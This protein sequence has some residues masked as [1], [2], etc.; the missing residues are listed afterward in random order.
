M[1]FVEYTTQF[2]RD[3][4]RIK[5]RGKNF[6]SIQKIMNLIKEEKALPYQLKD[7][8]LSGNWNHHKELHIEPDWLLIYKT[9][10][11]RKAVIFVRTGSHSD[12]FK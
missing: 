2:K 10:I 11:N 5:K 7:H 3:L 6:V 4:N 8:H 12:L 9:E 1:L